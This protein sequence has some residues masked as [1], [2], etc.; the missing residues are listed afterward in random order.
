MQIIHNYEG[1]N[2]KIITEEIER[3]IKENGLI[4]QNTTLDVVSAEGTPTFFYV[5]ATYKKDF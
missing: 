2:L 4:L 1:T 5:L 3:D